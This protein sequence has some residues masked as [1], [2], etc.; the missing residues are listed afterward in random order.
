VEGFQLSGGG[1]SKPL[2]APEMTIAPTPVVPG[3]TQALAGTLAI[4]AGAP[5]HLTLELR[6]AFRSYK[7]TARGQLSVIRAKEIAH[8]AGLPHAEGLDDLAGDPLAVDLSAQGPWLPEHDAFATESQPAIAAAGIVLGIVNTTGVADAV[9]PEADSLTGTVTLHNANWKAGYLAN[10]V[11]I[12]DATLHLVGGELHLDPINFVYGPLKGSATLTV[13]RNCEPTELCPT[14]P[15]PSVNIRFSSLDAATA[16]TAILGAEEKGTLVSDLLKRLRPSAAPVWPQLEGTVSAESFALGP[17][18]LQS[19]KAQW[20][21]APTGV[22]ITALDG[23]LLGGTL[24][25]TGTLV[26]GD[27]PDYTLIADL[28]KLNPA[29]VGQLLGQNW[30]GGTLDATGKVELAGFTGSDLADSAK[31]ALHFEWNH[32]TATGA[33]SPAELGRFDH[34]AADAEIANGRVTFGQNE[35]A[36]GSRKRNV[37]ASVELASPVKLSFDA[38]DA[39]PVGKPGRTNK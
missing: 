34:W 10:H 3:H 28:Q 11:L 30:R 14:V 37:A 35:I 38:P 21:T 4:P 15:H 9:D 27:K 23:K 17:V 12:S 8:A 22:E 1:L 5:V 13:P 20:K 6:L 7:L 29:A 18:T 24:H 19:A 2:S 26:T 36:L 16:Q 31:G 33:G 32:G 25:A 39:A